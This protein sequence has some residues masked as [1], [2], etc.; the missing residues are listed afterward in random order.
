MVEAHTV[1]TLQQTDIGVHR[2]P[3][4]VM[5]YG[6]GYIFRLFFFI[7]ILFCARFDRN[8]GNVIRYIIYNI[9][10]CLNASFTFAP[11]PTLNEHIFTHIYTGMLGCSGFFRVGFYLFF[12]I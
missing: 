3:R 7:L 12:S 1:R 6:S 2:S 8:S 5:F 4:L 10:I 11:L 9:G